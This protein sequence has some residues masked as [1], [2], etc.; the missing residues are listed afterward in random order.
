LKIKNP[1]YSEMEGRR[2]LFEGAQAWRVPARV[3]GE[4]SA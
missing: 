4:R 1:D 2:E 3:A